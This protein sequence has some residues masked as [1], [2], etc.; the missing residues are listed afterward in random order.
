MNTQ[1]M[2]DR[3]GLVQSG[4]SVVWKQHLRFLDGSWKSPPACLGKELTVILKV[5]EGA[6]ELEIKTGRQGVKNSMK[7]SACERKNEDRFCL[8]G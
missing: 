2:N 6:R 5:K 4:T 3:I 8:C 1:A 7:K